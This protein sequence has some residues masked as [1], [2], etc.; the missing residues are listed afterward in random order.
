[1][2][3]EFIFHSIDLL[4]LK[5]IFRWEVV[6]SHIIMMVIFIVM[7]VS[8]VLFDDRLFHLIIFSV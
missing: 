3:G 1:M 5:I 2:V 7:V 8:I 4:L 6:V